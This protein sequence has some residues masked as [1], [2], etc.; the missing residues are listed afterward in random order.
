MRIKFDK[1]YLKYYTYAVLGVI[2][3]IL[4]Y[5]ILDNLGFILSTISNVVGSAFEILLP[6]IMGAVLAYFLFRPM[7][8]I[9]KK[10]FKHIKGS[11]KKPKLVRLLAVLVIYVITIIVVILFMYIS[12]PAIIDSVVGLVSSI[13]TYA[14][15][16]NAFLINLSNRGGFFKDLVDT[17]QLDLSSLQNLNAK[18]TV[19]FI[20]GNMSFN[21]ESVKQI[22]NIAVGFAKGT[23]S[24]L[25]GFVAVFFSGFYLML[26]KENIE[27][28]LKRLNRAI[29]ST[30]ANN[31][32]NWAIRTID[33][34]FYKYFSGK[35][36]TSAFIGL[37]CY[38]G[39]L[40]LR[41]EYA[42]LIALVVGVTNVIPYFGPIIGAIPGIFLTL[43]YSPAKALGVAIWIL[44][45]QQFDGNVLGPNVLGKIVE[46]NPFWVLFC[47]MVGGSLFGPLG[48]FVA[49]PF[50]AVIKVFITEA[51]VRWER[52]K[53]TVQD[54][55]TD[56]INEN[57]KDLL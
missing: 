21:S 44:A 43:L 12:I 19:D 37:L 23:T 22:G 52:R 7:R 15:E 47:V 26:D 50:F 57:M 38:V 49:I 18:D 6:I 5:K 2:T 46:L 25:I 42:P 35:I 36:M 55:V 13:P 54:E 24:F 4:F 11:E 20:F 28:Q 16:I 48:M 40:V 39:L 29:L 14:A 33:G 10:A 17:I 27:N 41:V 53:T 3:I 32:L 1:Q 9:E 51:L 56:K 31:G 45:V 30:K 8:W 34:V